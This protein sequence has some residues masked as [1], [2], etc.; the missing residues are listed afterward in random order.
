MED[1]NNKNSPNNSQPQIVVVNPDK[2]NDATKSTGTDVDVAILKIQAEQLQKENEAHKNQYEQLK[3]QLKSM[4]DQFKAIG[5]LKEAVIEAA[6]KAAVESTQAYATDLDAKV[7]NL[8]KP[9][10][11]ETKR[12][13]VDNLD[14]FKAQLLSGVTDVI[15]EMVGGNTKEEILASF[16]KSREV[17]AQIQAKFKPV[18]PAT[19]IAQNGGDNTQ[20]PTPT[21]VQTPIT[22]TNTPT[23]PTPASTVDGGDAFKIAVPTNAKDFFD[24][25]D[26]IE[27]KLKQIYG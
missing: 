23:I 25:I 3:E 27:Q 22:Q 11:E 24:Q 5:E 19:P 26:S 6:K 18:E 8:V 1:N 16:T 7:V 14:T 21:T 13:A 4:S 2:T 17:Y 10:I 15:P 12:I 9:I 20:T